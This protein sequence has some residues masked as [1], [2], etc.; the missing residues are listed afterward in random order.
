MLLQHLFESQGY[1]IKNNS[2]YGKVLAY[3]GQTVIAD[4]DKASEL[5]D[6]FNGTL[7]KSMDG[8]RYIIKLSEAP[9]QEVKENDSKQPSQMRYDPE[10][11]AAKKFAAAHY[12]TLDPDAAMEKYLQRG[13]KH[14]E[15][16]DDRQ[17]DQIKALSAQVADIQN[18]VNQLKKE[19]SKL[20]LNKR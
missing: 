18:T 12:S 14:S 15:E 16:D 13:M 19:H 4:H 20:A 10:L 1:H 5:A 3:N 2:V 9:P 7:V 11:A 17:D 8:R 6:K